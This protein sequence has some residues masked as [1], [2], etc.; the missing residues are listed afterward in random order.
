MKEILRRS[1]KKIRTFASGIP[2]GSFEID[3]RV[4]LELFLDE[5]TTNVKRR[6]VQVERKTV[7][8]V[9]KIF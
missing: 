6:S 3:Q 4:I 5:N 8:V 9:V 7:Y 1:F 2:D